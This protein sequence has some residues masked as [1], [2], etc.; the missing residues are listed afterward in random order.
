M[1]FASEIDDRG[2]AFVENLLASETTAQLIETIDR[3]DIARSVRHDAIF[4]ARN[5]LDIPEISSLAQSARILAMVSRIVGPHCRAVRGLYFDKTEGA[6]WPVAWH[7]DLTVAIAARHDLIGWTNWSVKAG[8]THV[9]PPAELLAQ[10]ITVR[11]H[12]DDCDADNGP[13]KVLP[14]THGLGRLSA[15]RV[16]ELRTEIDEHICVASTGSALFMRPLLVHAS[17]AAQNPR[18]RRVI[19]LE[20]APARLLPPPL[21]WALA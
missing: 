7:Q 17:S 19:H 16:R 3:A 18:H 6:N 10:M 1:S 2:F 14:G 15:P 11:I 8:E 12:L 4:G 5:L 9:Q 13:L 20:F 21:E